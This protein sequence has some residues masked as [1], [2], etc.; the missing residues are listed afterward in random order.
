MNDAVTLSPA[1]ARPAH[2]PEAAVYDFDMFRDPGYLTD[3]HKRI[4]ELIKTAP[5]VMWTPRNGGH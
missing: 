5:P 2:I 4:M 1:V 3:P